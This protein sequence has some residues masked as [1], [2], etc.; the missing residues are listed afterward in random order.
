MIYDSNADVGAY[1]KKF[2][3]YNLL[4]ANFKARIC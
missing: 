2:D 1:S 4:A 3:L